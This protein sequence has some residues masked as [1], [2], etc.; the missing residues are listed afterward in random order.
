MVDTGDAFE[1]GDHLS[2]FVQGD[3]PR[4]GWVCLGFAMSERSG[5]KG[6]ADPPL[7]GSKPRSG[8]GR[9]LRGFHGDHLRGKATSLSPR[10]IAGTDRGYLR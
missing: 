1:D 10:L 2:Q 5:R 8:H 6:I 7:P 4:R 3:E 9:L